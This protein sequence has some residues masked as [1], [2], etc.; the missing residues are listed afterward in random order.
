M[1]FMSLLCLLGDVP[2][3]DSQELLRFGANDDEHFIWNDVRV[4]LAVNDQ[5][6]LICDPRDNR[7]L[8]FDHQGNFLRQLVREGQGPAESQGLMAVQILGDGSLCVL[9]LRGGIKPVVMTFDAELEYQSSYANERQAIVLSAS[10]SPMDGTWLSFE[11]QANKAKNTMLYETRLSNSNMDVLAEFNQT[12][13]R[14]A[15]QSR[16]QDPEYWVSR[17]AQQLKLLYQRLPVFTFD[18]QGHGLIALGDQY[19]ITVID[20]KG[21]VITTIA[22]PGKILLESEESRAAMLDSLLEAIAAD[23]EIAEIVTPS[24]VRQAVV[25]AELAPVQPL[26]YSLVPRSDGS[27]FVVRDVHHARG[28]NRADL[29]N[30][31]GQLLAQWTLSNHAMTRLTPAGYMPKM[32][33]LG[34][35]VFSLQTL[36]SGDMQ[37]VVYNVSLRQR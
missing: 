37:V 34:D 11:V 9:D 27:I 32:T 15:D 6:I 30:R 31:K 25:E 18:H 10:A 3:L 7:L 28:I 12:V 16:F 23:P 24:V 19:S 4:S 5:H 35:K 26:I 1:M 13:G 17:I 8:A 2:E 36:E 22:G 33:T 20:A 21:Q 29:I 14:K